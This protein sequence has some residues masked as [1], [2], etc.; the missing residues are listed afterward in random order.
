MVYTS[1]SE[2]DLPLLVLKTNFLFWGG[3]KVASV[4]L[5]VSMHVPRTLIMESDGV[6]V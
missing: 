3:K 4:E 5:V 1:C 6:V 2:L